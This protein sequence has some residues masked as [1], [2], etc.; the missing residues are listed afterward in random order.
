M[1]DGKV[2]VFHTGESWTEPLDAHYQISDN[3]SATEPASL[4]TIFVVDAN[5]TAALTTL[6]RP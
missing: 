1:N 3:A 4:L 2:Q 5:D 6:E